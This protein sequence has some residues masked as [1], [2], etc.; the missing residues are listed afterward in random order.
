MIY[1]DDTDYARYTI[2]EDGILTASLQGQPLVINLVAARKMVSDRKALGLDDN[3]L[4][5]IRNDAGFTFDKAARDYL[6]GPEGAEGIVAA[7]ILIRNPIDLVTAR[8][9][10]IFG[11]PPIPMA[12]FSDE[13][14]AK[15]WLKKHEMG[16]GSQ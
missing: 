12:Y 7:A 1:E 13:R 16:N 11:K 8:F 10:S 2:G 5:L 3:Q 6:S 14:K 15:A 9:M 4:L